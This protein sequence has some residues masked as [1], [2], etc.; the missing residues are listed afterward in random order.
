MLF[1][2]NFHT[3]KRDVTSSSFIFAFTP[4]SRIH[5]VFGPLSHDLVDITPLCISAR[6]FRLFCG[7]LVGRQGPTKPGDK[8]AFPFDGVPVDRRY[9][10]AT[11]R[12]VLCAAFR[13]ARKMAEERLPTNEEDQSTR[14][15]ISHQEGATSA[16]TPTSTGIHWEEKWGE[17]IAVTE[18]D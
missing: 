7:Y 2:C 18:L 1:L 3:L 9:F 15:W 14:R 6:I 11:R 4:R 10:G 5:P 16:S 8:H 12:A 17:K 13:F